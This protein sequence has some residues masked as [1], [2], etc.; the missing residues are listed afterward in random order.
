MSDV[1]TRDSSV[2]YLNFDFFDDSARMV[3]LV[4][5]LLK[6]NAANSLVEDYAACLELRSEQFQAI[7]NTDD[8]RGVLILQVG[9][10]YS[11]CGKFICLQILSNL[12]R[13]IYCNLVFSLAS[14]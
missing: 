4:P 14:Y 10:S 3:G 7:E 11:F 1:R 6:A 9:L 5:L 13:F 2:I 8:D 12:V